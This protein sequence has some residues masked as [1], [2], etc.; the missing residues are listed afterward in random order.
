MSNLGKD[1]TCRQTIKKRGGQSAGWDLQE[2]LD[3]VEELCTGLDVDVP[4][5]QRELIGGLP[6][7]KTTQEL[8]RLAS[9]ILAARID[10]GKDYDRAAVRF[11][12]SDI[13]KTVPEKFSDAVLAASRQRDVKSSRLFSL[14]TEK[15]VRAVLENRGALDSMVVPERDYESSHFGLSTLANGYLLRA[16]D[17]SLLETKQYMILRVSV[18]L[19][20]DE[21]L[22]VQVISVEERGR[23][24]ERVQKVYDSMSASE[25]CHA[26]PTLF[27]SGTRLGQLA[28]CFLLTAED[29]V[30]GMYSAVRNCA[31]ISKGAGGIGMSLTDVRC[32]GSRIHETNG[33]ANGIIPYMKV[34]N[35]VRGHINQSG[36]RAGSIAVYI[37][38]WHGEILSFLEARL[39]STAEQ[40][41]AHDLFYGLWIPDLF[42][43]RVKAKED[44][45]LMCPAHCPGLTEA[46][47]AEFDRLYE[48]YEKEGRYVRQIP[49]Q[50][51]WN[52]ILKSQ[53]ETGMP[54]ML[55]KDAVNACNNQQALGTI[56]CSNLCTEICEVHS[57]SAYASCNLASVNLSAFVRGEWGD[58]EDGSEGAVGRVCDLEGLGRAAN[59]LVGNLDR[60]IDTT[61]YPVSE[62]QERNVTARP[63]GIGVQGLANALAKAKVPFDSPAA[64]VINRV[65][66]E[67]IY[68]SAV[69]AS[70]E[71]AVEK[72]RSSVETPLTEKGD[73]H[74]EMWNRFQTGRGHPEYVCRPTI[75]AEKWEQLR[76]KVKR[77]GVRN[78]LLLA[79]MPT[80]S[81]SQICGTNE[82]VE[83]YTSNLYVRR[84]L[85]GEHTVVN[86][87]LLEHLGDAWNEEM[88]DAVAASEGSVRGVPGIDGHTASI[89]AT[90]WEVP[91]RCLID[92]AR[93]RSPWVD[94]SQSLTYYVDDKSKLTT[95][96]FYAW[97]SGLKTGSYY[98]RTRAAALAQKFTLDPT[99]HRTHAL[100]PG[101]ELAGPVCSRENPDCEACS[102]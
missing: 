49:S 57:P 71:L 2:I 79:L 25:V 98:I 30:G 82:S 62:T 16:T 80:A 93:E 50:T 35:A 31:L 45:S 10:A 18:A 101:P 3:R 51:V 63:L 66:F 33:E 46:H 36:K 84:T 59:L 12:A 68:F 32:K 42:M 97:Q 4:Q 88:R 55:Y 19:H 8:D 44:I 14:L 37:E 75:R 23:V 29:D 22:D 40:R 27:N 92:M 67:T 64:R 90:A 91:K 60:I 74:W 78:T 43:R 85:A 102:G 11:L 7:T 77:D 28:S 72:G 39:S 47:G 65:I 76:E 38:P 81:T 48:K 52:A 1:M 95:I 89:F 41:R 58:P 70:W 5:L 34:L 15:F 26:T 20:L 94:Q 6:L 96:H 53:I 24:L 61:S 99:K 87:H 56:K 86:P 73:F 17:G 54:Y 83:P 21:L 13:G 100:V 9:R 69:E